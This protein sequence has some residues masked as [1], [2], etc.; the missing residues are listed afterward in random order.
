MLTARPVLGPVRVRT[1][2]GAA[3][4]PSRV[5]VSLWAPPGEADGALPGRAWSLGFPGYAQSH[6]PVPGATGGECQG[7]WAGYSELPEQA[8]GTRRPLSITPLTN[9]GTQALPL[10]SASHE[11]GLQ[12][13]APT[14]KCFLGFLRGP[15]ARLFWR[16]LH[17]LVPKSTPSAPEEAALCQQATGGV[18]AATVANGAAGPARVVAGNE[19]TTRWPLQPAA[20]PHVPTAGPPQGR[21]GT[22]E[23]RRLAG[24]R[25]ALQPAPGPGPVPQ[26]PAG[27][28][29]GKQQAENFWEQ[30]WG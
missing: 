17:T 6:T 29:R 20:H 14:P 25:P 21:E 5:A 15:A 13:P 30:G 28:P 23:G 24:Q 7:F 3:L 16:P 8:R 2:P 19:N 9:P 22:Q 4:C 26:G 1:V 27:L 18:K 10:P 11:E 12:P